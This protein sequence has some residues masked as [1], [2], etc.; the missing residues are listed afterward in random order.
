MCSKFGKKNWKKKKFWILQCWT[1]F[2]FI[3][4]SVEYCTIHALSGHSFSL[5][6]EEWGY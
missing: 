4:V 1:D 2:V 3:S 6:E 5:A